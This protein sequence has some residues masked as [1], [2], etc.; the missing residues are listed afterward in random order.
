M[1]FIDPSVASMNSITSATSLMLSSLRIAARWAAASAVCAA[2]RASARAAEAFVDSFSALTAWPQAKA[3]DRTVSTR[4]P[5]C[6]RYWL[7]QT[8]WCLEQCWHTFAGAGI[9]L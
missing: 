5:S 3:T 2:S 4:P 6:S 9:T 7:F 8:D 1:A